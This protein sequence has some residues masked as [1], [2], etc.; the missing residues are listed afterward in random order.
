[1]VKVWRD[2]KQW[3]TDV[4][5]QRGGARELVSGSRNGEVKIWDLRHDDPIRTIQ[6]TKDTLRSLTLHEHAPVFAV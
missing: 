5:L 2:H 3:I 1:M 4:H 6:T